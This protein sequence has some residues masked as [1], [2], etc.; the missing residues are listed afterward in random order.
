MVRSLPIRCRSRRASPLQCR[1]RQAPTPQRRPLHLGRRP[2]RAPTPRRRPLH[3]QWRP[4]RAPP[5]DVV[6]YTSGAVHGGQHRLRWR[7]RRVTASMPFTACTTTSPVA[8]TAF[9]IAR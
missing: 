1:P 9:T 7:P 5:L 3:L 4:R 2:R 8:S 6:H